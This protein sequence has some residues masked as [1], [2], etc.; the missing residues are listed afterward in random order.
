M[1][2]EKEAK[3]ILDKFNEVHH[4][5]NFTIEEEKDS[6]ISFLDDIMTSKEVGAIRRSVYRKPTST[7]QYTHFLSF[8]PLKYKRNLIKCLF[9]RAK[10]I[11]SDDCF[12]EELTNIK[13]LLSENSFPENFIDEN[14]NLNSRQLR[15]PRV[16][17]KAL[18]LQMQFLGDNISE[19]LTQSLRNEAVKRAFPAAELLYVFKIT[20]L[21]R[22]GVKD[23]LPI[24]P[25]SC[26]STS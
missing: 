26:V 2:N 8:V 11:C 21:L 4:A 18:F 1:K 23:E 13:W 12:D 5:I 17:K 20:P 19:I 24:S 14:L 3:N 16:P 9:H 6:S 25:L 10:E 15:V 22:S 7:G